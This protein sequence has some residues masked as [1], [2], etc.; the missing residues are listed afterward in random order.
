MAHEIFATKEEL[1]ENGFRV[2]GVDAAGTVQVKYFP[3]LDQNPPGKRGRLWQA[4]AS[5]FGGDGWLD[6]VKNAQ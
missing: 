4:L 3:N 1:Y 5:V 6:G 2:V